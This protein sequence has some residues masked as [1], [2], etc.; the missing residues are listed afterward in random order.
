MATA[1]GTTCEVNE[2]EGAEKALTAANKNAA[3]IMTTVGNQNQRAVKLMNDARKAASNES[4]MRIYYGGL[5]P[6]AEE[7]AARAAVENAIKFSCDTHAAGCAA[8]TAAHKE[9]QDAKKVLRQLLIT[10]VAALQA[11]IASLD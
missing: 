3:I 2:I 1:E 11:Q 8:I 10:K 9:V 7:I 6:S 4:A 5:E